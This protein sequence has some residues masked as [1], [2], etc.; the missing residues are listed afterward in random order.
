[1]K[2]LSEI[3]ITHHPSDLNSDHQT[4]S[5]CCQEATRQSQ[6]LDPE[7]MRE[8]TSYVIDCFRREE[9]RFIKAR[10]ERKRTNIK[11]LL[12][13]YRD[14]VKHVDKVVFEAAQV[15]E[16]RELQDLLELMGGNRGE[17]FRIETMMENVATARLLVD[18][19][20]KMLESY[21]LLCEDSG[22]DEELRRYRVLYG[23]YI[24]S[25]KKIVEEI[26]DAEF[27]DKSTIY[28]DV[29]IA[30]ERLAVLFFGVYGLKFF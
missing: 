7:L 20:N 19:M 11:L 21:R 27:V 25:E 9:V 6:R 15:G 24:S 17:S 29:D 16:D 30:S 14:I 28:R 5:K 10:H 3:T 18:H 4:T 12:Q 23:M 8:I 13:K 22:K 2:Y 1:M 26:A